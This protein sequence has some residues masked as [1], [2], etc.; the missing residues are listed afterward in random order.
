MVT[1]VLNGRT[2]KLYGSFLRADCTY[3]I[4]AEKESWK[5]EGY[6]N[7]KTIS[8][9]TKEEPDKNVYDLKHSTFYTDKKGAKEVYT[10]IKDTPHHAFLRGE[11]NGKTYLHHS[12]AALFFVEGMPL[13]K[14]IPVIKEI[15]PPKFST[16]K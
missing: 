15:K 8:K 1:G 7:I 11:L 13:D 3:E 5:S 14:P 2:E 16:D 9:E 10:T 4:E 6:K 12:N